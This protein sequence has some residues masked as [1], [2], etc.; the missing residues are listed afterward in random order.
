MICPGPS[1][2]TAIGEM[3]RSNTSIKQLNLYGNGLESEGGEAIAKALKRNQT[4]TTLDLGDNHLGD[5]ASTKIAEALKGTTSLTSLQMQ[6][7]NDLHPGA[8]G[9][10][11][12]VG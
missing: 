7:L 1:G 6:P 4:L 2:G 9:I 5:V 10:I 3:L 12:L 8:S 11:Y